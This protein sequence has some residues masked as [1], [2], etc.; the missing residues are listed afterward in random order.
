MI[1]TLI[2]KPARIL[3]LLVFLLAL[4]LVSPHQAAAAG[5]PVIVDDVTIQVEGQALIQQVPPVNLDGRLFI[6]VRALSEAVGGTIEWNPTTRQ[7]TLIRRSDVLVLTIDQKIALLNGEPV[8][9]EHAPMIYQDRTV[10][11][12]RFIAEVLGGTVTWDD[13][14]RT[15]N[16]L[17]KPTE[18]K[19]VTYSSDQSK[20][21]LK[22]ALSEPFL[23]VEPQVEG[24]SLYLDLYPATLATPA[25]TQPKNDGLVK[26]IGLTQAERQVRLVVDLTQMVNYRY[27][28][29]PDGTELQIEFDHVVTG[30]S[31]T[32]DG[33]VGTVNINM[34]GKL[35]YTTL[36]LSNPDRLVV[37][38]AGKLAPGAPAT[39]EVQRAPVDRIRLAQFSPET[40]RV[41]IDL[42]AG[43]PAEVLQTEKGLQVRFVPQL[44][45]VKTEQ[46]MGKTR[47]TFEGSL[48]LDATVLAL[49][50]RKQIMIAIP[51]A[52]SALQESEIKP[53]GGAVDAITVVPGAVKSSLIITINLPYYL[54][55]TVLT[56]NGDSTISLEVVNSPVFGR[57]IWIDA[58]HGKIPGGKDDPGTIGKLLKVYE[59]DVNLKIALELQKQ[60]QAAGAQVYMTRTGNEGVD[61]TDRPALVN[62][63]KPAIDLFIS[64]H[65]NSAASPTAR[66]TETYYWTTNPQ[67]KRAAELIHPAV[68]Q[69]LGFPDRRVRSDSFYVIKA[70][71]APAILIEMGYLSNA[72]EE[73]AI[74]DLGYPARAAE[75]I[76]NGVFQYF[77]QEIQK[78]TAK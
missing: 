27:Q 30:A 72:E 36:K 8:A 19:A 22:L 49:A 5:V 26:Q 56:K 64:I 28:Y 68:V 10:V 44:T 53:S 67:S 4:L 14:S 39:T 75:G 61:F 40:V 52:N 77:W 38:I 18:I 3:G 46:Q 69:A 58:G 41:V 11:P 9:M 15:A 60:L 31:F 7:V 1:E 43:A 23:R 50:D 20:A 16:I 21:T 70:T 71:V 59:K 37:D 45:A 24:S 62:A 66:G 73:Q 74:A 33:R 55:H 47:I 35:S 13:P 32:Q 65:H 63:V 42:K 17:R 12:L 34:T 57:R 76:K 2:I 6:G 29:A 51:Q 25:L 48:P 54:G 78:P